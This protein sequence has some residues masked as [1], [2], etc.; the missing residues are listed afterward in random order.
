MR[1]ESSRVHIRGLEDRPE[2][3]S[4]CRAQGPSVGAGSLVVFFLSVLD[5]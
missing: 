3:G 1:S 2:V 5:H 4:H